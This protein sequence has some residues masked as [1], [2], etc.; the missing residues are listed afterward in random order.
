MVQGTVA[1]CLKSCGTLQYSWLNVNFKLKVIVTEH[2]QITAYGFESW[3][4]PSPAHDLG[5]VISPTWS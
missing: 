2:S 5:Q 1:V 4:C 3:L